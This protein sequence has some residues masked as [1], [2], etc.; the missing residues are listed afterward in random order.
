MSSSRRCKA[1]PRAQSIST[2]QWRHGN[3]SLDGCVA[4]ES[5]SSLEARATGSRPRPLAAVPDA[6]IGGPYDA[7]HAAAHPTDDSRTDRAEPPADGAEPLLPGGA[8]DRLAAEL[9][10]LETLTFFDPAAAADPAVKIE[11]S[12]GRLGEAVLQLRAQLIQ[13]DV[14]IRKGETAA[15]GRWVRE[16]NEWAAEHSDQPLLAR[17][18]RLM[19]LFYSY[20]GDH[21]QSLEHAVR[22]LELL[23]DDAS[24]C[25]RVD[26]LIALATALSESDA[27]PDAKVRL[28]AAEQIATTLDDVKW[29]LAVLNTQ[30][31]VATDAC[32][33][34]LSL[35]TARR[36]QALAAAQGVALQA[37]ELETL[38]RSLVE[39]GHYAEAEATLQPMIDGR[40][41]SEEGN[42]LAYCL[43][44][45]SQSQTLRGDLGAA[46]ET[47]NRARAVCDERE[48]PGIRAR[49]DQQ[50][51]ELY[52]LQGR[53]EEAYEQ[54][55]RFYDA[56]RALH[57]VER[58]ARALT[59]QAVFETTEA[60]RDSDRF[61][62]LALHDPLTAL[63]NRRFVD[64]RLPG[65][66]RQ[67]AETGRPLSVGLV[68]LDHF[69]VINDTFSH[70]VG[71]EVLA[72]VA[73]MLEAAVSE[74]AFVARLGGEEFLMVLPDTD[75]MSAGASFES[76]RLAIRSHVW[77]TIAPIGRITISVGATTT[78]ASGRV[79]SHSGL[80]AL[81]D[82]NLYRA[83]RGG[84]DRVVGGGQ[85]LTSVA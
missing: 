51:A 67:V 66:L 83:K 45:M 79:A 73:L 56:S 9:D 24:A 70:Q 48:L 38:A 11:R 15:G 27:I 12:A 85:D 57:S 2:P 74:P 35:E 4:A 7:G 75:A 61:E 55:K 13:A 78:T 17:S 33:T 21:A 5:D 40:L 3:R 29:R 28:A 46:L 19:S 43:L 71:D 54:H 20:A 23:D 53:F 50:L 49:A 37:T 69:K 8:A 14:L 22:G 52:A 31:W 62:Q 26:H 6:G 77:D 82:H 47:I 64:D 72:T 80:L 63:Y 59:V 18:H 10:A 1:V 58:A 60:R 44:T 39:T 42:G 36:M 65:L 25:L 81:A 34:E 41:V 30:A 32:E 76:V 16:I 84:R 68:D